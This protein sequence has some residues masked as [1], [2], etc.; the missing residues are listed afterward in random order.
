MAQT[1]VGWRAYVSGIDTDAQAFITAASIT[2]S[3]QKSAIDTLVKALKSANIWTK[4]KALY[5]MVG[6]SAT[7]HKFNLKDPRDL[8][9]AFRLVFNG[10]WTHSSTGAKPNGTTAYADTKLIPQNVLTTNDSHLSFYSRSNTAGANRASMGS[11]NSPLFTTSHQMFLRFTDGNFYGIIDSNTAFAQY[12][13]TNTTGYYVVSRK[14]NNSIKAYKNSSLVATNTTAI[15]PIANSHSIFIGARS[16]SSSPQNFDDKETAFASIGDGLTDG[17]ATAFYTAVQKYQASLGRHIISDA[18]AQSF[19]TAANITDSTQQYAI[20]TLVT[21]LKAASIWTKLKAVYPF[22]GGNATSHKFN[23][24]SPGSTVN[25]FYLTFNG[26][27]VHSVTGYKPNGTTGYADT[28]FVPY[29]AQYMQQNNNGIGVYLGT[30]NTASGADPVFL[31]SYFNTTRAS[32][33]F[34]NKA[35]TLISTRLNGSVINS[36]NITPLGL[37]SAQRTSSTSTIIYQN[38]TNVGS[39]NSGGPDLPQYNVYIGNMNNGYGAYGPSY[40]NSEFRFVYMSDGLSSTEISTLYTAVQKYQTTL[41][42]QV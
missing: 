13:N 35:N 33:L 14:S 21:D 3:T 30:L 9:A 42:R 27:G 29:Y 8:D 18:D 6:G 28:G 22:V 32:L 11:T 31:G 15:S 40:V 1:K 5:P 12:S 7:S 24:K 23:L 26:G 37:L 25:D 38:S 39:G 19:I 36:T 17:E 10:G 4:M 41:G 20:D 34:V 16:D 2:D